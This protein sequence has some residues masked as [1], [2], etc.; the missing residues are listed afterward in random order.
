MIDS[1]AAGDADSI[2]KIPVEASLPMVM[3]KHL[4][5]GVVE[6]SI[7]P[8]TIE[9]GFDPEVFFEGL[10]GEI[11]DE[12]A[13]LLKPIKSEFSK[14]TDKDSPVFIS[15]IIDDNAFNSLPYE[16][17]LVDRVFSLRDLF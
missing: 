7:S 8:E 5:H 16:I 11:S 17:A 15:L 9:F 2:A 4:F 6:H 1:I 12:K 13:K 10:R 3:L 14:Q